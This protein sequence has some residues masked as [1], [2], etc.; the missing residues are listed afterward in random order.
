MKWTG[1]IL[2]LIGFTLPLIITFPGLSLAG[3]FAMSI[4]LLAAVFWMFETVPIYSTSILVIFFQVILLSAEGFIDYSSIDYTPLPFTQFIATLAD[5]I[6]I[7][8]L[9]GFV[10]ADASVKYDFDKS[11]TRLLLRPFGSRPKFIILGLMLVT[12]VL[13]AFMS[14]TA[15]TAMMITVILPIVAR[16]EPG[17][18]ARVGIAL[19]IPFAA[20]I[21]GIAT[22][23]G[24]PPNAVVIAALNQQG[25]Q[26]AFSS[27]MLYALPLAIVMLFIAWQVLLR[28]YPPAVENVTLDLSGKLKKSRNAIIL[29]VTFGLTVL[30]WVTEGLHGIRSSIVA[31]MPVAVLTLTSAFEK[32]D[33]R[34]LPWEVLWLIA[35]G[36]ALGISM[37]ETGLAEWMVGAISW[38]QFGYLMLL[39]VFGAVALIMSNFLSNTVTAS[40]LIPLAISLVT[41]GLL[42][43]VAGMLMLGLVIA[44][45]SSFAMVLPISTP[46]NAIAVSTGM[47]QTK[48]MI[49]S[50]LII[51]LIGL[52]LILVLSVVYWPFII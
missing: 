31:L 10:L 40:L 1:L 50:G 22:P 4:F 2:G 41:S 18:P 29:Y 33:I 43:G 9:G 37:K 52:V 48:D 5:P 23:I 42:E 49:S 47:V 28:L 45:G 30:L 46:P 38:D 19:S 12:A 27:W 8:F 21:G 32:Q 7:L 15:T 34:K 16:M 25:V 44:L 11:M 3:H 17:D 26:V 6:I 24:T 20:N 36:I 14:N 39:T 35:G 13:S 51:G